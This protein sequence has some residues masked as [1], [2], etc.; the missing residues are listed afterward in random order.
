MVI[1][2]LFVVA[3]SA[4]RAA[5]YGLKSYSSKD[6][7]PCTL[8]RELFFCRDGG[9][10]DTLVLGTSAVRRAGSTPVRAT[11]V[12][13]V[14]LCLV[15]KPEGE[16][17]ALSSAPFDSVALLVVMGVYASGQSKQTVNLPPMAS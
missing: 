3:E 4:Y 13:D 5:G 2:E 16:W 12:N 15:Y 14:R 6:K 1:S 9:T 11:P 17:N 8:C 7:A 10:V